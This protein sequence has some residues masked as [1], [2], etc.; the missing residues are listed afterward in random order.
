MRVNV[1]QYRRLRC[2]RIARLV[3]EQNLY[4]AHYETGFASNNRIYLSGGS[5]RKGGRAEV[6]IKS[7]RGNIP[8]GRNKLEKAKVGLRQLNYSST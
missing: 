1:L 8:R 3:W 4:T 5:K 7:K 2:W 6:K